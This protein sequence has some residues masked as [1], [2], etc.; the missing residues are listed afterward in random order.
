MSISVNGIY[1]CSTCRLRRSQHIETKAL[2][3]SGYVGLAYRVH[4]DA[5]RQSTFSPHEQPPIVPERQLFAGDDW[6]LCD[7]CHSHEW[8]L[9]RELAV[10]ASN[11]QMAVCMKCSGKGFLSACASC[12]GKGR[13]SC[14][15]NQGKVACEDCMGTGK[16]ICRECS[17]AGKTIALFGLLKPICKAC[18]GLGNIE[19]S[20]CKGRGMLEHSKC[21]GTGLIICTACSGKGLIDRCPICSG[22][23]KYP[24]NS[25][26]K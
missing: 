5:S 20:K 14:G 2:M 25:E 23:G 22:K 21:K 9:D 4:P 18:H 3:Q 15:C 7:V 13:V 12:D 26:E 16:V 10:K 6:P 17:G 1:S 8:T 11:S 24:I 19:H